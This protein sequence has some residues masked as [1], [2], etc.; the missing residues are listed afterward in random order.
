MIGPNL[1]QVAILRPQLSL[2]VNALKPQ[3]ERVDMSIHRSPCP[4]KQVRFFSIFMVAE[5]SAPR[6]ISFDLCRGPNSI[7]P[8]LPLVPAPRARKPALCSIASASLC[9][10][11]MAEMFD[12]AQAFNQPIGAWNTSAVTDM[13]YMFY[14]A[15]AFNQPIGAWDTSAVTN[16]GSMF[17]WTA[18]NQPIG[19]W[20]TSAVTNMGSM[21]SI[22]K[23]PA[24]VQ[25]VDSSEVV[26]L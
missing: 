5:P 24:R 25:S 6:H 19:A 18:F 8:R 23:L 9:R 12:G 16:M 3:F 21:F 13:N 26:G 14:G 17:A 15:S 22:A 1:V 11:D 10:R 20:D 2:L 4:R 7:S